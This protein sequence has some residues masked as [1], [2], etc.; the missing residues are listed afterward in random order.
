VHELRLETALTEELRREPRVHRRDAEAVEVVEA[1]RPRLRR[2]GGLERAGAEAQCK[3][4][5]DLSPALADEIG[6]RDPAVDHAV[7]HVL[8]NVRSPDEQDVD[9]RITARKGE[10]ALSGLLGA[11]AR[12]R[13]EGDRRLAQPA[14]RRDS[15]LQAVRPDVRFRRSSTNRYPS[16]PRLSHCA[17][18]VTVVVDAPVR[19][20]TS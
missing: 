1:G 18:R 17:T 14:L 4:L 5:F 8:G 12:V 7:L 15:D 3:E 11:E 9:R 13:E 2:N 20:A 19:A 6:A 10:R 16:A